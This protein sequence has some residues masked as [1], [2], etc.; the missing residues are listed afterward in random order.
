MEGLRGLLANRADI[1]DP[2]APK[3]ESAAEREARVVD[4]TER[5]L[6]QLTAAQDACHRTVARL[7]GQLLRLQATPVGSKAR[8]NLLS[9][10]DEM[11]DWEFIMMDS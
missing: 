3:E 10:L 8:A 11:L 9:E 4:S 5:V 1:P 6:R 7:R 2:P